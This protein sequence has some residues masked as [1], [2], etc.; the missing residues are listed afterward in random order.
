M[1]YIPYNFLNIL[2]NK[3]KFLMTKISFALCEKSKRSNIRKINLYRFDRCLENLNK[4]I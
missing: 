4:F 1:K 2:Y 3:K